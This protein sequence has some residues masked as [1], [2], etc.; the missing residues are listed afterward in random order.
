MD[1]EEALDAIEWAGET[2]HPALLAGANLAGAE[3]AE[4]FLY[5][6]DL[7]GANLRGANLRGADLS[8]ADLSGADLDYAILAS[9]RMAGT[10]IRDASLIGASLSDI[11]ADGL[12]GTPRSLP[13]DWKIIDGF[14][15]G[16][17]A[18][19]KGRKL[20]TLDLRGAVLRGARLDGTDFRDADL[21]GV[22]LRRADLLFADLRDA[23]LTGAN[24]D[25][26]NVAGAEMAGVDLRGVSLVGIRG[27][28]ELGS[29]PADVPDG[30]KP[31]ATAT[32]IRAYGKR[33][34]AMLR[35]RRPETPRAARDFKRMYPA[36]FEALKPVTQGR[37][38]TPEVVERLRSAY[39][40]PVKWLITRGKYNNRMQ[41]FCADSN[42]VLKFN[43][44]ITG[45]EYTWAQ[46][47]ILN[48]LRETSKRSG[49]PVERK[50]FFTIGWVRYCVDDNAKTWLVEEVQSDI[51]GVRKGLKDPAARRQLEEGGLSPE[52]VDKAVAL[53]HPYSEHFYE[54]ALGV[55]FDLAQQKGYSVEMLEYE[56]KRSM[57]SPRSVYTDLPKSMGM[58]LSP[59]S[60]VSKTFL[61]TW[62]ITPNKRKTSRN[63]VRRTSRC[64]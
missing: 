47:D 25:G 37:D 15:V 58:R 49:H 9:S 62:K 5:L 26:A 22:D 33:S 14:L 27:I 50:P 23:I 34:A 60:A 64:R 4:M 31:E 2:G 3:L 10:N 54:D 56:D 41:R 12:V 53:V 42:D 46:R 13:D 11:R 55:V 36:E 32:A 17:G 59:G 8:G 57:D 51:Q 45:D 16:P 38:F 61:R 28:D 20:G 39:E 40:S 52:D 44:R 7:R 21:T 19:L 24:L 48:R 35:L 18:N 63:P 30:L 29:E 43:I 6:A 1:R